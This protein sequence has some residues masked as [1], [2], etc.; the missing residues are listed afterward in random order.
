MTGELEHA[1]SH[2]VRPE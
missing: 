1:K 2:N